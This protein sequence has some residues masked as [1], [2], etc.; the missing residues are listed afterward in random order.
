MW[1][2]LVANKSKKCYS[3][4]SEQ[5]LRSRRRRCW[6]EIQVVTI[7]FLVHISEVYITHIPAGSNEA[8]LL[9]DSLLP[10]NLY[11]KNLKFLQ[12]AS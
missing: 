1:Y 3:T 12:A 9:A 7:H 10:T 2:C 6:T 8:V 11:L 4:V 5:L